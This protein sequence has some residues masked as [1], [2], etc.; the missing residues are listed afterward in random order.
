MAKYAKFLGEPVLLFVEEGKILTRDLV[1][2]IREPRNPASKVLL[3]GR[4]LDDPYQNKCCAKVWFKP[5]T[6]NASE[7]RDRLCTVHNAGIRQ[8]EVPN[9]TV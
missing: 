6:E 7:G 3:F 1:L 5:T 4:H 9:V 8:L 2:R